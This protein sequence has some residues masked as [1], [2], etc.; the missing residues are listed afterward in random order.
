[1]LRRYYSDKSPKNA[2]GEIKK[3]LK[4]EGFEHKKDS[5]YVNEEIDKVKTVIIIEEFSQENKWFPLCVNKINISPNVESL[6]ISVMISRLID[7]KWQEKI[8]K[9]QMARN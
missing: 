9:K 1:M 7:E 4:R 8:D 2:Y 5:D 6:D 3:M